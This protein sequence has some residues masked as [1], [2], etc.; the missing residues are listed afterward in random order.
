MGISVDTAEIAEQVAG[1]KS[2]VGGDE[3]TWQDALK[4]YG[5]LDEDDLFRRS[6]IYKLESLIADALSENPDAAK[7]DEYMKQNAAI[8]AGRRSSAITLPIVDGATIEDVTATANEISNKIKSGTSFE[9]LAAQY[10]T[11]DSDATAGGSNASD[12][13]AGSDSAGDLTTAETPSWDKGWSS[14]NQQSSVY[15]EALNALKLDQVSDPVVDSSDVYIIKCTGIYEPITSQSASSADSAAGDA[16]DTGAKTAGDAGAQTGTDSNDGSNA[17]TDETGATQEQ[18]A[19]DANTDAEADQSAADSSSSTSA[20]SDQQQS[21]TAEINIADIPEDIKE[22]LT[23]QYIASS[24]STIYSEYID[25]K[26]EEADFVLNDMPADV[27]YNV[28]MSLAGDSDSDSSDT[29]DQTPTMPTIDPSEITDSLVA[30]DTQVG[31]GESIKDGDQVEVLYTG[32][33]TNG[34]VFDSSERNGGT[35]FSLTVGAGQVIKGWDQGLVGM[36]LG[37]KR[38]LVIPP[39]LAYGQ[40]GQGDIPANT[41]IAFEVEIVS[42]NEVSAGATGSETPESDTTGYDSTG[43]SDGLDGSNTSEDSAAEAN[44]NDGSTPEDNQNGDA[45]AGE[46]E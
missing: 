44:A 35:P 36:K 14:I 20:D 39:D 4:K 19:T 25:K 41:T 10:A 38:H 21:A 45:A 29:S 17:A 27:P 7:L 33:F 3:K 8:Y 22:Y 12:S 13:A 9:T 18:T 31:S 5:Y 15:M 6:E 42:V 11:A 16:S 24:K 40:T 43:T 23:N 46:G 26:V 34:V 2:T 32:Y 30:V 1:M 28:D 37:G